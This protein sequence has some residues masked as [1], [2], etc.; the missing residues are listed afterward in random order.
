MKRRTS[1]ILALAL[2]LVLLAAT[3]IN[4]FH[5]NTN[6]FAA[7]KGNGYSD[8]K[9]YYK[10]TIKWRGCY[11]Q[12]ECATYQVPIDYSDLTLGKFDIAVMRHTAKGA[13]QSLVINPGGPGGSGVDYV[14]SYKEAFTPVVI[15]NFDIVGFDPR[16]VGESAPILCLSNSETDQLYSENS[17]P[18]TSAELAKLQS[19]TKAFADKCSSAN[20]YLKYYSTANTARD[21]DI[22]RSVLGE[23]QLNFLGKSY[24]TYLGTL[25]SML[26]PNQVG[27]FVLDGAVD[28]T[29]DAT[30]QTLQQAMGFDE[31]F[32]QFA[33]YCRKSGN[34]VLGKDEVATLTKKL[35]ELRATPLKV[36]NRQLTETLATYGIAFGLYES[37]SGWPALQKALQNL[38]NGDG[39][40]LITMADAYT[41]RGSNGEYQTNEAESLAVIMCN[42]FPPAKLDVNGTIKAA[43]LFGKFVAYSNSDCNYFPHGK[44][45]LVNGKINTSNSA[46]IIGTLNDPATP[47]KWAEKLSTLLAGSKLISLNSQGHTGYNRG[48]ACVDQ[49]VEKYLISG[50]IP[51]QN[52]SCG[53]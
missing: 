16:G 33:K 4:H 10:Q 49:A 37:D 50:Q 8:L 52:L 28:P 13:T 5:Q 29:L 42:D 23:A 3:L 6:P 41:G 38:F 43:P 27:K 51:A 40:A 47:Y 20:P 36:G 31:A 45:E 14:Y 34:C 35:D 1:S 32:N 19:E 22:L 7:S 2:V 39:K 53:S 48:S 44:Y 30:Q 17:Y 24:G 15:K 12:F 18:K 11:Q 21:M 46:L 25:Y 26:F 9:S